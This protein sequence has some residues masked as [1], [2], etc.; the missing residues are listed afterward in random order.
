MPLTLQLTPQGHL[1]LTDLDDAAPIDGAAA[2]RLRNAFDRGSGTGLV[3]LGA[4]EVETRLPTVYTFWRDVAGRYVTAACAAPTEAAGTV[5]AIA[6]P[7]RDVLERLVRAAPPMAG[8]EYLT[9]E[10]LEAFWREIDD[11]FHAELAASHLPL[12]QFLHSKHPGWSVVGRVH[13]NL[14]EYKLDPETPFAFLATY[15]TSL[16]SRGKA[17]HAPL[18]RALEELAGTKNRPRLLSL[19]V[20]VQ[21][22]AE[23][24]PW[25]KQMVDDGDVFY[26]LQWTAADAYRFLQDVPALEAAGV[27]VRLPAS[28]RTGRPSRP[29]ATATIGTKPPS[30]VGT[31]ALLDFQMD[32]TLD[33]ARLS[34]EE[35]ASLVA[36]GDGLRFLRGQ[37]VEVKSA[38]LQRVIDAFG[39]IERTAKDH[40]VTFAEAMRLVAAASIDGDAAATADRQWAHVSAG[41]WLR[42]VLTGLRGPAGLAEIEPM[43]V[44]QATLRPY[45]SVGV[46]WLRL[47]TSLGLGACLADDMG[48]GKTLQVLTLVLATSEADGGAPPVLVVAPASLLANWAAEASRFAPSLDVIVAHPSAMSRDELKN[49][50]PARIDAADVILTSYTALSRLPWLAARQWRLVVFDEAQ[51]IKNPGA[52]QTRA[53]RALVAPAR[54]ALTGTPVENRLTD[55][56]SIFD[57]INPGLLG[58]HAAFARWT[59]RLG[60]PPHPSFAPLRD[61]VRPYILRR[62]KT[63]PAVI[64][65]LPQKTE[66]AAYCGL[67]PKQAALYQDAV[68]DLKRRLASTS[69]IERRGLVLSFL[70]RFKQIVNHPSHWLGDNQWREDESGKFRR[71]RDIAETI[72]AR[73][74]KALIFTQFREMTTP[75]ATFLESVFGR[76]GA[77]LHGG[78]PVAQRRKIVDRFQEDDE[79]PFF[80]LSLKAGGTGLNLTAASHVVHFDRWWNPAVENQA[81]DRA[82]RIG[83][84]KPVLVHKFICR[85][86]VEDRI[87][88]LIDAKRGL[89]RDLLEGTEE[90]SLTELSD[91]ELIRLVSLDLRQAAAEV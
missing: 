49:P 41:G 42:D 83:Q 20:P 35:I 14:A 68:N 34:P 59:K 84:T 73:Q 16:S 10:V 37:W 38:E 4:S 19:L 87:E 36:G 56:W 29:R 6:P 80:V 8:L 77:V 57:V 18:G 50:D 64:R 2:E 32:V 52:R 17:Q 54:I 71:L 74:E 69:G 66:V 22:A 45:Q 88:A 72:A 70:M 13:F 63:D 9:V 23:S 58:S 31:E 53:A 51:A 46:R 62:M 1:R 91:D 27:I 24:C 43:P 78:T 7:P 55:L 15:T 90:I 40:G 39:Q 48:L 61:L 60:A 28:W 12:Q 26:P 85:G 79:T 30:G 89:S 21:R 76:P 44:L 3:Q 25:L 5:P 67:T 81:T 33:G 11:A 47:L 86:T 65:D 75:L 82:F